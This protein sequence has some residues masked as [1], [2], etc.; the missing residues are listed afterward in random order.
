MSSSTTVECFN[1]SP[2]QARR[3]DV[4]PGAELRV[5]RGRVWLTVSDHA[6]DVFLG[7]GSQCCLTDSGNYVIEALGEGTQV[8]VHSPV[9]NWQDWLERGRRWLNMLRQGGV[10]KT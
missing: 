1:L 2:G 10:A 4:P 3:L 7:P 6:E 5:R 9:P 8:E